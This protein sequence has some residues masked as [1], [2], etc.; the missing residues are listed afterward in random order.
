[1][2]RNQLKKYMQKINSKST[3]LSYSLFCNR[4]YS[5][6]AELSFSDLI[7]S[8]RLLRY[9]KFVIA[10]A[11]AFENR[12]VYSFVVRFMTRMR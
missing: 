5:G 7:V 2:E 4:L 3:C 12:Q 6:N 1:M 9:E 8:S 10:T 11:I